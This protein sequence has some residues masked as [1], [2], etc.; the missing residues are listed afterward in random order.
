MGK[1]IKGQNDL[2]TLYPEIAEQWHPTLNGDVTPDMVS[3]HS[4]NK[5]Y[6]ICDE[7]H[8]YDMSPDHRVRGQNCPYCNNRRLLI[9]Y[10]DLRTKYPIFADEWDREKNEKKPEDFTYRSTEKVS[11][12]CSVCGK[13]FEAIIRDRVDSPYG[14]CPVCTAIKRGEN[15]LKTE[16]ESKGGIT[17]PLLLKEWDYSKNK[18]GPECFRPQFNKYAYW[19]CS[20]CGYHFKAKI[21]NRAN[22]RNCPCCSNKV[23]VKGVNDLATTHPEIAKE[24]YQPENGDLTPSD[25]T[26]GSGKKVK[27]ICPKGHVYSAT[28]LHRTNGGTNCPICNSG[29]QTSFAEQAV[30]FYVKKV[31]PNA[32]NHYKDIFSNGMELDI[33]IPEIK[34]GIEYDGVYWHKKAN[35][36]EREKRKHDVCKDNG[37]KLLRIRE[38]K[39]E[40]NKYPAADYN[41]Y[42]PEN[43]EGTNALNHVIQLVLAKI[44]P[45][46]NFWTRRNPYQF[47]SD[48]DVNI[49]R[50]KFEI[51]AY[52]N[53]PVENSVFEVAPELITEWDYERNGEL[54]PEMIKAGSSVSVHWICSKCGHRWTAQIGHRAIN[55]TGCPKCAGFVFENGVNDLATKNPEL[56]KEWDYDL[57]SAE[58]L[59]PTEIQYNS[60]R[61]AHWICSKCGHKWVVG[62]RFRSVDGRGCIK[63]GYENAKK[64]K[65]EKILEAKGCITNPLLL[66][67][68]DYEKNSAIGLDPKQLSPGSNKSAYWICSTCG[69]KWMAPISR[70]SNGSGCRKCADKA[71]PELLIQ[72]RIKCGHGL[73]DPCLLKEWDYDKNEK[74][75]SDYSFGSGK[76]VFWICSTC[77]HSWQATINSRHKG[78]GCPACAGNILVPGK[79]D[80]LTMCPSIASEWDYSRNGKIVPESVSYSTGKKYWW[81]CPEGH[82]SYLASPGHRIRG[83]G[84]PICGNQKIS[85]KQSKTVEQ[86]S[87]DGTYIKTYPSLKI[88]SQ[89]CGVSSSAI[90]NAIKRGTVSAGYKWKYSE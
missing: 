8:P 24:W 32:I 83:T 11:W 30:Y 18:D 57:N 84:C 75:P 48:V 36:Y 82:D 65:N 73:T 81:I 42:M 38:G 72:H 7:R 49:D 33:Y 59:D 21:N 26:Y 61:E 62:I 22:G 41:I 56:L 85:L 31:F 60:S 45:H 55:H 69:Y 66:K 12:I 79:N 71:N 1:L 5:Y 76:K 6:W 86:Y 35:T 20:K 17:D 23:I 28:I 44:D 2:K 63:C 64:H 3:A 27:W 89:E 25:V 34:L 67:E 43:E 19:I 77:G 40:N 54:K 70:R 78:A 58:G 52:L 15:R 37:I 9:G 14:G 68:W 39:I 16:I 50:D 4:N 10:N 88:A 87:C 80:L 51:L 47:W 13:H 29:R 90:C 74:K 46:S 53:T